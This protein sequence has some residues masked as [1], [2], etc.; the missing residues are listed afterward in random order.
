ML[1]GSVGLCRGDGGSPR[2]GSRKEFRSHAR[3]RDARPRPFERPT[4][5]SNASDDPMRQGVRVTG[6]PGSDR[7]RKSCRQRPRHPLT[8]RPEFSDPTNRKAP[9]TT[10]RRGRRTDVTSRAPDRRP[11]VEAW[12]GRGIARLALAKGQ[13]SPPG[14]PA[15]RGT[16][17]HGCGCGHGSAGG[18]GSMPTR[19]EWAP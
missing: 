8:E 6:G 18:P 11:E 2:N 19:L 3:V 12:P 13:W 4:F 10:A 9:W 15:D 16:H 17:T 7:A 1:C 5:G 14:P